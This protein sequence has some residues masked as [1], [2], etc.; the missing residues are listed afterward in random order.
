MAIKVPGEQN[1]PKKLSFK[2]TTQYKY[3]F[4]SFISI[5][6]NSDLT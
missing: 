3:Y 1:L 5:I 6:L 2:K 4:K